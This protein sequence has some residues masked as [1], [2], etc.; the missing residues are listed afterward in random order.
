M[1]GYSAAFAQIYNQLWTG[2]ARDLAPR[3]YDFYL[4]GEFGQQG[5][6]LLDLCCGTG[7]L[8]LY[9]LERGFRVT[10][11][12]LSAGM[13][14]HAQ[15]NA[16]AFCASGQARF[17]QGDA[18]A[19]SLD[20]RFGLV[21]SSFDALNHLP[22]FD[23]LRAC[24]ACVQAVTL[25]GG[26]FIFD[27]NTRLGLQRWNSISVTENDEA[28]IVNHG[29]YDGG[30]KA[31]ARI[32]G[33]ARE[34]DGRYSRF[35]ENVYNTHFAL[36]AVCAALLAGGWRA[37]YCARSDALTTPLADPESVGRAFVIASR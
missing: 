28:L 23:A 15:A 5:T 22:S 34:A 37:A 3:L 16:A 11:L 29:I 13:L 8:A 36:D 6:T 17:V 33:F 19:F 31:Y 27:L 25:P 35:E 14:A 24:F 12:D 20:E 10:G 4:Q 9:F 2:F 18:A 26:C 1:Q 21:I 32:H 30:D 7:Q